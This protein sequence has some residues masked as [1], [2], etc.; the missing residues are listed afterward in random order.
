MAFNT[1]RGSRG[2]QMLFG[3]WPNQVSQLFLNFEGEA[4]RSSYHPEGLHLIKNPS[5]GSI[6]TIKTAAL[7]E[8]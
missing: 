7:G 8:V 3:C 4:D 5:L 1:F 6:G 2:R